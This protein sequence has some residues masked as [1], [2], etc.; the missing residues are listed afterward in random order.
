MINVAE[1]KGENIQKHNP[2]WPQKFLITELIIGS[3][4]SGKTNALHNLKYHQPDISE[5]FLCVKDSYE[6]K[7]YLIKKREESGIKDPNAF[8]ERSN[9]KKDAFNNIK[10]HNLGNEW[11]ILTIFVDM[12]ADMISNTKFYPVANGLFIS[13]RKLSILKNQNWCP[14]HNHTFKF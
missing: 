10:Q 14:S 11:E 5:I 12:I 13:Y 7:Y 9:D 1:V 3:S 6:P 4:G 8:A 2:Y